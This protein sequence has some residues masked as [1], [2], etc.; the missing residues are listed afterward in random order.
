MIRNKIF[1][2]L[3]T[4]TFDGGEYFMLVPVEDGDD[5][6]LPTGSRFKVVVSNQEGIRLDNE[7]NVFLIDHCCTWR[8]P[9]ELRYYISGI[10]G[11][12]NRLAD[13]LNIPTDDE[14]DISDEIVRKSWERAGTYPYKVRYSPCEMVLMVPG[15]G[16]WDVL[17]VLKILPSSLTIL[18]SMSGI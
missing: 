9:G 5:I 2:K 6:L 10:E 8:S 12:R 3:R 13:I 16:P 1:E 14:N 7:N 4:E 18:N 17:S 11:L 15:I